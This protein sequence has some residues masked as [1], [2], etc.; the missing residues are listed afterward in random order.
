MFAP[1]DSR[2]RRSK[3]NVDRIRIKEVAAN[4]SSV[5]YPAYL[6]LYE[7]PPGN[8]ITLA[9]FDEI[10]VERLRTLKALENC[11]DGYKLN[12]DDFK[13]VFREQIRKFGSKLI[14]NCQEKKTETERADAWRRDTIGHF[15]LRLAFCRTVENVKWLVNQEL[16]L[17]KLRFMNESEE[18][19]LRALRNTQFE[20]EKVSDS[21][22]EH[23][24]NKLAS[25]SGMS[26]DVV[27]ITS[28]WKVGF[29]EALDLIRKRQ[30]YLQEGM[31]YVPYEDLVVIICS[32][33]RTQMTQAMARA[34]KNLGMLEEENRLLPRLKSLSNNAYD[35]K[36]YTGNE[37]EN[38][39]TRKM[40]DK[41]ASTS[42][43]LCM[44]HIHTSLRSNHHLKYGGRRQYGLFLKAI[45][46]SL[47]EA[48]MLM[49]EE[50]TKKMPSDKF[51][52]EYAYNIRYMYGKEGRRVAQNAFSCSAIILRNPPSTVDCH[53]CPYRHTEP[54]ILAQ[55]LQKEGLTRDQVEKIVNLSS[56]HSYDK[57]CSR[58]FE[59]THKM[60]EGALG[61]LITHPNFYFEESQKVLTGKR[62][63]TADFVESH[64]ASAESQSSLMSRKSSCPSREP[65]DI[66]GDMELDD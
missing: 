64:V 23:L 44:K 35:G 32:H 50:F 43:P 40:L 10:A 61:Q 36:Q 15:I 38:L 45:G 65:T 26:L 14:V 19:V 55:R 49:R 7:I 25:G 63:T 9:E 58:F 28:F 46:L 31:A 48:M 56:Q 62:A 29:T 37:N 18:V 27:R 66:D 52:K 30:V 59:Y 13:K 20:L 6:Q 22:R 39:V 57:A 53:G 41:L 54:Q 2:Q 33:L 3:I 47:D 34:Y 16:D 51:D 17:F 4:S 11:K 5:D 12:D 24:V 1:E 60:E 8:D 21:E 42:F